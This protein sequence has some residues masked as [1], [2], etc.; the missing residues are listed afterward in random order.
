MFFKFS[1]TKTCEHINTHSSSSDST[2][3]CGF[4]SSCCTQHACNTSHSGQDFHTMQFGPRASSF[5]N[6]GRGMD[7][8][9]RGFGRSKR[10]TCQLCGIYGHVVANC[11]LRFDTI[12][13]ELSILVV[14]ATSLVL[15]DHIHIT[16][17][18]FQRI[19][20][21]RIQIFHHQ[22]CFLLVLLKVFHHQKCLLLILLII[23]LSPVQILII[24]WSSISLTAI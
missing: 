22:I 18:T 5:F 17:Y 15:L 24:L 14:E 23:L 1:S 4:G 9:G 10:P 21:K 8:F 2:V 12:F 11:S 20:V 6:R 19:Q 3:S 16:C 13:T 7:F